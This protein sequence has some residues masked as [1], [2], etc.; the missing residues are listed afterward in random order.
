VSVVVFN[1]AW[2]RDIW[3]E[4]YKIPMEKTAVVRNEFHLREEQAHVGGDTYLCAWRPTGFKNIDT[5]KSAF[6]IAKQRCPDIKL[7]IFSG[8]P[9]EELHAYMR[10]SRALIIPSLSEL[11]PNLASEALS[12]GLP[13]LLT[14]DCGARECFDGAVTWIDPKSPENIAAAMCELLSEERYQEEK[15]KAASFA[16][17]HSYD[18]IAQEFVRVYVNYS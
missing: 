15:R 9:R 7:D 4:P 11:M 1:T 14:K 3:Q 12:L 13:V 16:C 10:R 5:L 8:I 6:E 2:Q 18:D 17:V